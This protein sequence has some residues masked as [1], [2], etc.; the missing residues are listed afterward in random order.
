MKRLLIG[1]AL[2]LLCV[3][4]TV[5]EAHLVYRPEPTPAATAAPVVTPTPK[6]LLI[7]AVTGAPFESDAAGVPIMNADT[8][9][10]DYYIT[11]QNVRIYEY[12]QGTFLDGTLI[13]TY[14]ET[15]TGKLRITFTGADGAVYGFGNL[16]TAD[17]QLTV[18]PGENAVYAEILTEID[19]QTMDFS[20]TTD[21]VFAP[22][23]A[24]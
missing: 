3:S 16:Y 14:P 1:I 17:G 7:P 6:A 18:L 2:L 9:Y 23:N 19:V 8:H 11:L 21:G 5:Q 13:S 22:M 12:E 4:C 10:L 20:I 24:Q 15:L